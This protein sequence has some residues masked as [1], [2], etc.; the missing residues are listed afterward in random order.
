MQSLS[1]LLHMPIH[2]LTP[3]IRL[4]NFIMY[5]NLNEVLQCFISEALTKSKFRHG[6]WRW[7]SDIRE[8][9]W[10]QATRLYRDLATVTWKKLEMDGQFHL[11]QIR[12]WLRSTKYSFWISKYNQHRL[13]WY[14]GLNE[15]KYPSTPLFSAILVTPETHKGQP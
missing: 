4:R 2:L 5:I 10:R 7:N 6:T 11:L 14:Y 8:M 13:I 12:Q 3:Q 9:R 15:S 1:L